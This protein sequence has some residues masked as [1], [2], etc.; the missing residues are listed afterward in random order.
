VEEA[1]AAEG[2]KKKKKIQKKNKKNES[3]SKV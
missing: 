1:N 2:F 3:K